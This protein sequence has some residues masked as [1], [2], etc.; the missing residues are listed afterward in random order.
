MTHRPDGATVPTAAEIREAKNT[1]AKII[2]R[3][4][5][6]AE[7][8]GRLAKVRLDLIEAWVNDY[9]SRRSG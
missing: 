6:S 8:V 1:I 5:V 7:A 4:P 3:E 2:G 9:E